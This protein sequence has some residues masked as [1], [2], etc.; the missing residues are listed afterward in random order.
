M[1]D[2]N[3]FLEE[4][5][6]KVLEAIDKVCEDYAVEVL[7]DDDLPSLFEALEPVAENLWEQTERNF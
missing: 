2:Y 3:L 1:S 4:I 6:N 7:A 5:R